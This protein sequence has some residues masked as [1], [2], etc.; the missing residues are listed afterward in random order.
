MFIKK[1]QFEFATVAVYVDDMNLSGTLEELEKIV[2][3]LK[4]EFEMKD[5]RKTQFCLSLELE[6]YVDG[7]LEHQSIYT[8]KVLWCFNVDKTKP[9]STPM[10]IRTLD[11]IRDPFCQKKDKEVVLF[12]WSFISECNWHFIVLDSMH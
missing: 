4:S 6:H 12:F 9:S 1:S 8:Q 5:L 11:A 7:I 2:S 10:V 3:H